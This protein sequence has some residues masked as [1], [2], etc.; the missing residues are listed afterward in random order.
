[1][2]CFHKTKYLS[3]IKAN[4]KFKITLS[5]TKINLLILQCKRKYN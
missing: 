3:E 5:K 2:I 1:M 4:T